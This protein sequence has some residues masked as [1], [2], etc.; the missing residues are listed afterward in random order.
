MR[1]PAEA[2]SQPQNLELLDDPNL[3]IFY[4]EKTPDEIL[5]LAEWYGGDGS[6]RQQISFGAD[7]RTRRRRPPRCPLGCHRLLR[8]GFYLLSGGFAGRQ[9]NTG[10]VGEP[11][12]L[13]RPLLLLF[14]YSTG[15][16]DSGN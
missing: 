8:T 14:Y 7:S 3:R 9:E 11:E 4:S 5:R 12:R 2:E 16:A 13:K 1:K 10:N 15:F 6:G